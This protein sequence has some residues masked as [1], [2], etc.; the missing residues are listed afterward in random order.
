MLAI[1]GGKGGTGKTTVALGLAR[2]LARSGLD[3]LVVDADVDMPD[4]H[5]LTGADREPTTDQLL[6]DSPIE[7][8]VQH[9]PELPGV[10]VVAA[11]CPDSVPGALR[12]LDR[13]HG[14]VLV[15]C[16]AGA[17]AD[18]A[19]PLRGCDLTVLVTTAS[20][21]AIEN[22]R[23]TAAI[24]RRLEAQPVVA[25]ARATTTGDACDADFG[26]PVQTLPTVETGP[27]YTHPRI[28]AACERVARTLECR[29]QPESPPE[30]QGES[31]TGSRK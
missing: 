24:G 29:R 21:A 25:L 1:A 23:K 7:S 22:T 30:T 10:R 17:G 16:P 12:R 18:A 20:P 2:V 4:L 19:R 8:V 11:G 27:I 31:L 15:D 9:A 28:Q 26:C 3:P 14:P 5:T 6:T 13:W